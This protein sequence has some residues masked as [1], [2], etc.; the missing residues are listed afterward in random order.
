MA[1]ARRRG[2]FLPGSLLY[3]AE[4]AYHKCQRCYGRRSGPD[5]PRPGARPRRGEHCAVGTFLYN[6]KAPPPPPQAGAPQGP[7]DQNYAEQPTE[8]ADQPPPPLPDYAAASP[9]RR[10]LHLDSRLL[11]LGPGGLL[12]GS[13]R[14]GRGSLHGRAVDA[15]LLGLLRRPLYA[16]IPA[17]GACTSASTAASTTASAMSASVTRAAIGTPATSS[18]TASTTTSMAEIV[19]NVYSYRANVHGR[20]QRFAPAIVADPTACNPGRGRLKAAAW[21]EP[22][23]PRMSTQV[24]HAQTYQTNRGQ[25]AAQNHGRPATPAVSHPVPAD[26]NVTPTVRAQSHSTGGNGEHR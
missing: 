11:G 9:A 3:D 26:H 1:P 2:C 24:Q 5:A 8:T 21:H 13:R 25:F 12:L 7:D 22:T 15:R 20:S 4:P 19:H 16:S 14:M 18:I 10:R 23:A 17:T 6:A